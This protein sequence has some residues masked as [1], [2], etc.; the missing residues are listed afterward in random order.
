MFFFRAHAPD[1]QGNFITEEG[2]V[3]NWNEKHS[4]GEFSFIQINKG[5]F[6]G[7]RY[8]RVRCFHPK[9]NSLILFCYIPGF[10]THSDSF[11]KLSFDSEPLF[12]T[13]GQGKGGG[14]GGLLIHEKLNNIKKRVSVT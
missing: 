11:T 10:I 14:G 1:S 7:T 2:K 4:N 3:Q 8:F 13:T 12:F 5:A 6:E 9:S